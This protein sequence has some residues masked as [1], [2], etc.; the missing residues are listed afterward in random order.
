VLVVQN[1]LGTQPVLI[2]FDAAGYLVGEEQLDLS[3]KRVKP[4]AESWQYICKEELIELL[5]QE[6]GFEPGPIFV[7]EL[8]SNLAHTNLCDH[9]RPEASSHENDNASEY[10]KWSTGQFTLGY[11]NYRLDGLGRIHST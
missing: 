10:W 9:S 2:H 3:E 5:R 7:R 4:P 11:G 1:G 8:E 6:L